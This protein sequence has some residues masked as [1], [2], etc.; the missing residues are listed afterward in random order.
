MK[1]DVRFFCIVWRETGEDE[2]EMDSVEIT[3]SCFAGLCGKEA[4]PIQYE[5]HTVFENGAAQICLTL[6]LPDWPELH[7]LELVKES[8]E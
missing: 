4:T 7:E 2:G 6:D 8:G 3:E 5:R 1:I